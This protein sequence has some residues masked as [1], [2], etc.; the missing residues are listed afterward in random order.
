MTEVMI[1]AAAHTEATGQHGT[2]ADGERPVQI[3]G[4]G[5]QRGGDRAGRLVVGPSG[6]RR[7]TARS[8]SPNSAATSV[9]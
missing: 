5:A 7:E 3:A 2:D 8:T 1:P 9:A 6:S 4:V